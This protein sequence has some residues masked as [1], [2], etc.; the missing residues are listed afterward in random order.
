MIFAA[1]SLVHVRGREWVVLP[2]TTDLIT[3]LRPLGGTDAEVTG[4]VNSLE[5]IRPA[6][7]PLPDPSDTG[8][9]QSCKLLREALRLGFRSSAGPFRSFG[10][11]YVEPRPYQLV[12]LLV[13]LK[14]DPVRVLIADDVG[15]G[16]TVEAMLIARELLDRAEI[17]RMA[18]LCPP[19]LAEQWQAEIAKKFNITAEL[20]LSST[21]NRLT[22]DLAL[23]ESLFE[24]HPFTIVS[25]DFVK[26]ER[27]RNDFL[28]DAPELIIVD[29]AHTCAYSGQG[30]KHQRHRLLKD[31]A[32]D[33]NRHIIL[34]TATPHSGDENAFR[35]LLEILNPDF[36]HLPDDLTGPNM[37]QHRRALA[38]HFI[39]RRRGDIRR[40]LN[41]ATPFPTRVDL[42]DSYRLTPEYERLFN[43]AFAY[44][45]ETVADKEHDTRFRKRV[46]WWSVLALL[47]SLASSPAAAAATLRSRSAGL[48]AEDEE[49]IESVGQQSAF[50]LLD[51]SGGV[52]EDVNPGS[53]WTEETDE[54][55]R[56]RA[57]LLEM[58]HEADRLKGNSDAKL[59]KAVALLKGLLKDGFSPIVFCR[60]IPTA[61]YLADELR[62]RLGKNVTVDCVTGLLA[63]EDREGRVMEL[64]KA[65]KGARVLV[66]TDCL[67]EGINLQNVFDA[68][69]HYDLS[70]NPTRHEQRDGR[71]DRFGQ[72]STQ[73]R[74]VTYYGVDNR[75]DGIV[76][77]VLIKKHLKI[78]NSLGISVPI[79][80]NSEQVVNAIFEGLLLRTGEKADNPDQQFFDFVKD[81]EPEK[82]RLHVNWD[83]VADREKVSQTMFAQRTIRPEE[84]AAELA[85]TREAAGSIVSA[86]D[87]LE[88]ALKASGATVTRNAALKIRFN[89]AP[90]EVIAATGFESDGELSLA[91]DVL[92]RTHPAVQGLASQILSSALD[93]RLPKELRIAH[94]SGVTRTGEVATRTT[95]LLCRLRFH[96]IR[97]TGRE[98]SPMLAEDSL[99]AAF[100]G[101]PAGPKWLD[102]ENVKKLFALNPSGNV[103]ADVAKTR[104][105]EILD[106]VDGLMTQL[107]PL[108]AANAQ[109]LLASHERVRAASRIRG[110]S[111]EV[112]PHRPPDLLAV[113][114][115]LP[116]A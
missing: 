66:C 98:E 82:R 73:V 91:P 103:P 71:V 47:R 113:F 94:R 107:D 89:Q 24:V 57:R 7:F 15:I 36:E 3:M 81:F 26:S 25:T 75:I 20:V 41:E 48:E 32:T 111:Y 9:F 30:I 38:A 76:L 79:P 6:S 74:S 95:L 42:E 56:E 54:G 21:V 27:N 52:T 60:F 49:R 18:I 69:F 90:P 104:I 43:R 1:G 78:R 84:V 61:E 23:N 16:K 8:D 14:L 10:H 96:I 39:Q 116:T 115:F 99:L 80:A 2:E 35:S 11:I 97:R 102:S 45:R 28:R 58:A 93:P 31:L 110:I 13:A 100:E 46:R 77:D 68:V 5:E 50:D 88:S 62:T 51:Q 34:V 87:F 63:P 53:D 44:A 29:E 40:Y 106:N 112:I 17:T 85:E 108:I 86:V 114:Q 70:W 64:E 12:P 105:Q 67:S 4:I 55:K 33:E 65:S 72:K 101:S 83:T 19:H 109:S 37:E 59:V 92:N 22:K